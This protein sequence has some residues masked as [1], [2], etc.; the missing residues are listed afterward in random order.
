MSLGSRQSI[1]VQATTSDGAASAASASVSASA[2][3]ER[4]LQLLLVL[5]LL[6]RLLLLLLVQLVLLLLLL[7]LLLLKL[8]LT[9]V[10]NVECHILRKC[11]VSMHYPCR[12][13]KDRLISHV[14]CKS[15]SCHS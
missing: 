9:G 4:L 10:P 2:S 12:F 6:L 15:M 13:L 7:L 14:E 5:R 1:T 3:T 11:N 8:P